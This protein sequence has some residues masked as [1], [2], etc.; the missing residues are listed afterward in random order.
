[1]KLPQFK[2]VV[3]NMVALLEED[4]VWKNIPEELT[5]DEWFEELSGEFDR[6]RRRGEMP[7]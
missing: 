6:I 1:M 5:P 7:S 4:V 2:K 3:E